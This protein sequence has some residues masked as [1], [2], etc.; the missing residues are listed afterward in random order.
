G[1]FFGGGMRQLTIQATGVLAAFAFVFT[2]AF[3]LFKVIDAVV[4][5]RVS[6]HEEVIGLDIGEHGMVAYPDF[7]VPS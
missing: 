2:A 3:I 6:E 4:G 7:E 5:L 1:L